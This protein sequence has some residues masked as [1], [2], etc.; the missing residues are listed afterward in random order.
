MINNVINDLVLY[1]QKRT[2]DLV[3]Q[4]MISYMLQYEPHKMSPAVINYIFGEKERIS[5]LNFLTGGLGRTIEI[6]R[7]E[8]D[9]DVMIEAEKPVTINAAKWQ[10]NTISSTD[11]PGIN[12]TPIQIWTSEKFFTTGAIL[13]FDDKEYTARVMSEPYQD[14][15]EW[16]FN[17]QVSDGKADSYIPPSLLAQGKQVSKLGTAYEEYSEEADIVTYQSPT[18]LR[19]YLTTMRKKADI[20]GSAAATTMVLEM[21]NPETGEVTKYW[22][23]YQ[24]WQLMRE[25]YK[26]VDY[27]LM[28]DKSTVDKDGTV[29]IKGT[30]GRPIYQ[31]AGLLQ[32]ISPSNKRT[33]TK[34][35][36]DILE[37]FLFD[38]SYGLQGMSDRKF[39]ALTG[40]MG[41]KE[42]DRVLKEKASSYS[43]IDTHF[44]TGS[45]QE[46]TLGGQFTTYKM[47][48]G[49]ELTL[50]HFP[51]Y[52][53][54]YHNRKLHPVTG[55]PVESY[56]MTF[57]DFSLN[58]GE[59]NVSKVV[60]KGREMVMWHKGGSL[61]PGKGFTSSFG[62]G[63]ASGLDGATIFIL[64]ECGI[65]MKNPTTSGELILDVE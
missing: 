2:S 59:S 19:N 57:I 29:K 17:L 34:L 65:M 38:L 28:Y 35:T 40:E 31:G 8:Y 15:N 43:L 32:Q 63:R 14:G 11:V 22:E 44:V 16:V 24:R 20:T 62:E 64:G 42:L 21:R 58:D 54:T 45:G 6:E 56:R 30:N 12:G 49:V 33:Y 60:R 1:R 46:L 7:G 26:M 5:V 53:D 36:A 61:I 47:L 50:K 9:W 13:E 23:D 27:Q 10:G 52:D 48:N 39:V 25:W 37:E 18:R 3:D 51:L 4:N 41:M 55:K